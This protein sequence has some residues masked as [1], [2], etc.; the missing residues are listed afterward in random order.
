MNRIKFLKKS[1]E[2]IVIGGI[3]FVM[4]CGKNPLKDDEN[5]QRKKAEIEISNSLHEKEV[6]LKEIHHRVKNNLQIVSS[7]FFFQSKQ[8]DDPLMLE[9]FRDGQNRVKSMALI[10][11]KLYQKK[12]I[13]KIVISCIPGRTDW[14]A[15]GYSLER[16]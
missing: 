7:L 4:S 3:I 10:H 11:E 5:I 1:L 15:H 8:I 6:L 13:F 16:G 2:L 14:Q 9:M 12:E